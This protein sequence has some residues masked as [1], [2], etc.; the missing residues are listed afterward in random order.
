MGV[1]E[2]QYNK[3]NFG[4]YFGQKEAFELDNTVA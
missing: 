1:C 3:P 4:H 2:F